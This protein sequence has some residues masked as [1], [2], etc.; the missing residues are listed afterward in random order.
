MLSNISI[1]FAENYK[2]IPKVNEIL[3]LFDGLVFSGPIG[4]SKPNAEIFEYLLEKYN[5]N[6]SDTVFI[7]DNE[8]NLAGARNVGIN[9]IHFTGDTEKLRKALKSEG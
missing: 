4:L 7:D 6:A 5:L 3:S 8:K 9:T 1:G 2:N